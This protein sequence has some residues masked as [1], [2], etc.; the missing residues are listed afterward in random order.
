M[1]YSQVGGMSRGEDANGVLGRAQ[2]KE[3]TQSEETRYFP[4]N[5][6]LYFLHKIVLC[7]RNKKLLRCLPSVS[8]H[9]LKLVSSENLL[10]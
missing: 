7:A 2:V 9:S 4:I 10:L 1:Q 5:C 6:I 8:K 3:A